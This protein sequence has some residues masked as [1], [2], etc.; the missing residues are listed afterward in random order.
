MMLGAENRELKRI[1]LA[2]GGLWRKR[3]NEKP[4]KPLKTK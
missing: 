4:I 3:R 2:V 1:T